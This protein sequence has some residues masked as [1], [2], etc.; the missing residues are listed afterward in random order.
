MEEKAV[1]MQEVT[2]RHNLKIGAFFYLTDR[3]ENN[4]TV[5]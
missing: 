5:R 3:K 2:I 4:I 1:G